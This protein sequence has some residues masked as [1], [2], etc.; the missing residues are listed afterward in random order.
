MP[1]SMGPV[2]FA[3]APNATG[4]ASRPTWLWPPPSSP[5]VPC[6]GPPGTATAGTPDHDHHAPADPPPPGPPPPAPSGP[7]CGP[8]GPA[9][10]GTPDHDHHASADL[11]ADALSRPYG[12]RKSTGGSAPDGMAGE[13]GGGRAG[14]RG[15]GA[16][17]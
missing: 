8:P 17:A 6:C 16:G 11:L 2:A 12:L 5:S 15:G 10:A 14:G 7:G 3:A 13:R 4:P 1:G 9:A